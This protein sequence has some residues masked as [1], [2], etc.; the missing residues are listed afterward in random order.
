MKKALLLGLIVVAAVALSLSSAN[1]L[2]V[3]QGQQI[4]ITEAGSAGGGEF[5]VKNS[6][7][8]ILFYSF[9]L[10][11]SETIDLNTLYTIDT[12]SKSAVKGGVGGNP[13]PISDK[14]A[15]LYS[16]FVAGTLTGYSKSSSTQG[17]NAL[18][19]AIWMFE[20]EENVNAT[21]YFY[22]LAN[23]SGWTGGYTGD[24]WAVNLKDATG[25]DRQSILV[26]ATPEPFTILLLGLGLVGL[27]GLRRK[28]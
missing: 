8:S 7:N 19:H 12:I 9:C 28:E 1:A 4:K 25:A 14:T 11:L 2:P 24:V 10:E 23:T 20:Q 3:S 5:T 27:A 17:E 13:D 6:S 15:W 16:N 21:N 26:T 18:Q 22:N